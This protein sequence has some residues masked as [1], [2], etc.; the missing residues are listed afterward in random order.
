MCADDNKDY[1]TKIKK[2]L[3][4]KF[5]IEETKEEMYINYYNHSNFVDV[6]K[7]MFRDNSKCFYKR[8]RF[9][10]ILKKKIKYGEKLRQRKPQL[11][12]FRKQNHKYL[13]TV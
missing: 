3:D 11:F 6:M 4:N 9:Y 12:K 7:C 13:S 2:I 5:A 8:S 10:F 1:R